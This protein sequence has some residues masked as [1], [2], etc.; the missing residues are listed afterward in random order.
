MTQTR[1]FLTDLDL[2]PEELQR[3]LNLAAW[4]K[5]RQL[6]ANELAD[7]VNDT[8]RGFTGR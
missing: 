3:V 5:Q 8:I 4:M 2:S 6:S 1:H 7:A